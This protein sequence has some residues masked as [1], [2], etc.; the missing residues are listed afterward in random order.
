MLLNRGEKNIRE[1]LCFGDYKNFTYFLLKKYPGNLYLYLRT[2]HGKVS[3]R[4]GTLSDSKVISVSILWMVS[5][6]LSSKV[7]L[8]LVYD[9]LVLRHTSWGA[10]VTRDDNDGHYIAYE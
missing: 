2:C 7:C 4:S 6:V 9:F 8:L 10:K 5:S 1:Y 3:S